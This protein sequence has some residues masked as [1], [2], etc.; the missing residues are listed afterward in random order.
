MFTP[1]SFWN[2]DVVSLDPDAQAF[3][4]AAGITDATISTAIDN[5]VIGLKTDNLWNKFY[6]LYPIVG[7]TA[8]T[9]KWNLKDPRDLDAAFRITFQGGITHSS[10]GI[11]SNGSSGYGNTHFKDSNWTNA[12]R[13]I[14]LYSRTNDFGAGKVSTG[15]FSSG[16][17][18]QFLLKFSNSNDCYMRFSD[19]GQQ[20]GTV[21]DTRGFF[22]GSKFAT[23]GSNVRGYKNNVVL[24]NRSQTSTAMANINYFILAQ[25][26]SGT[27]AEFSLR[28]YCFFA[29][30]QS[31]ND[32]ETSNLYTRVQA[33]QTALS[34]EM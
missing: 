6:T 17:L 30:G 11:Q 33:L 14:S 10:T 3:L 27:A 8:E 28:E 31:F 34:R 7:G 12:N 4:T 25:N 5:F 26:G 1:I 21:T 9:H 22:S 24:G 29:Y 13:S 16:V 2:A 20:I 23:S 15:I 18:T 32:V 19:T